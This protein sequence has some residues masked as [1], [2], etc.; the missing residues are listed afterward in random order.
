MDQ[1]VYTNAY[2]LRLVSQNIDDSQQQQQQQNFLM[3][4]ES[5]HIVYSPLKANELT[6]TQVPHQTQ[7]ITQDESLSNQ[8]QQYLIQQQ[9]QTQQVFYANIA[10]QNQNTNRVVQQTV[11]LNHNFIQQQQNQQKTQLVL[12]PQQKVVVQR[13]NSDPS[14]IAQMVADSQN[15][16]I[17]YNFQQQ[18]QTIDQT[19]QIIIHQ[20][21]QQQV[22]SNQIKQTIYPQQTGQILSP[23]PQ[24]IQLQQIQPQNT[25]VQPGTK[26]IM[27]NSNSPI[28]YSIIQKQQQQQQQSIQG[29]QNHNQIMVQQQQQQSPAQD[30]S[31]AVKFRPRGMAPMKITRMNPPVL[32]VQQQRPRAPRFSQ[33]RPMIQ[34]PM[35]Q[36]QQPRF[37]Q[38]NIANRLSQG[39]QSPQQQQQQTQYIIVQQQD[40]GQRYLQIAQPMVVSQNQSPQQ[41]V[42]TFVQKR[43]EQVQG[44]QMYQIQTEAAQQQQQQQ[45]V[46]QANQVAPTT[47]TLP[48]KDGD[49]D[50]LEDSITATAIAK[51]GSRPDSVGQQQQSNRND[52]FRSKSSETL[53]QTPQRT[54]VMRPMMMSP[55]IRTPMQRSASTSS[56]QIIRQRT[57]RPQF[58]PGLKHELNNVSERESAKMLVIL[59]NGEQRLITFTLPKETCTV[60]ELLDQV[61]IEIGADSNI[62]CIEN[63]S[64]EI[65]YIV[66]VGNFETKDTTAMTKAAEN[67]IR[68]QQQAQ[69]LVQT[70]TQQQ[71]RSSQSNESSQSSEASRL[72]PAKYVEGSLAVCAACGF[73]GADHAKCERCNRVFTDDVKTVKITP[74]PGQMINKQISVGPKLSMTKTATQERKD[75]IEA[76]QKKHQMEIQRKQLSARGGR[77]VAMNM[78]SG[79]GRGGVRTPRK[80]VQTEIVTLSS[81]EESD[82]DGTKSNNSNE[83]KVIIKKPYEPDIVED[84]VPDDFNRVDVINFEEGE[85]KIATTLTCR[86]IRIGSYKFDSK[87]EVHITSKG[88]RIVAPSV[89]N[90]KDIT[91]LNIQ[92]SEIIKF[93]THFSKQ[94]SIVFVYTKPSCGKYIVD[95]LNMSQI[96]D[97]SP[98][99]APLSKIETQRK[100]VFLTDNVSEETKSA[101]RSIYKNH[102][103][104]EI[105]NRDA[106]ELLVR[107]TGIPLTTGSSGSIQSTHSLD[108]ST[109]NK[110]EEGDLRK[111]LTYPKGRG[112]LTITTYDYMCLG[113]D[114]YLNDVIIDFYLKYVHLEVL[115]E[116][117]R[118]KTHIFSQF[119]Y[120]RLTTLVKD[121]KSSLTAA[122]KRH[123]RVQ[124]WTKNVN[125]FEK[126]FII[127]PINEQSHWFLAIICFPNL[128]EPHTMDTN[129]PIKLNIPVKGA[130]GKKAAAAA[131]LQIGNTT[132]T[133]LTKTEGTFEISEDPASERDEAEGDES[134]L[135]NVESDDEEVVDRGQPVKVPCILIFDSLG[136]TSRARVVATLRD[137]LSCEYKAKYPNAPTRQYTKNN[138]FGCLVKV[139]QQQNFTDC[140]LFLLQYVEHFFS[141]PIEDFRIP[142][143][144][145]INWFNQDIVT[146]KREDISNL[147][148]KL[149]KREGF[150]DTDFPEIE[151][152]TKDGKIL[153]VTEQLVNPSTE[154]FEESDFPAGEEIKESLSQSETPTVGKKVYVAKKRPL[155]KID[156]SNGDS[157]NIKSP[158]LSK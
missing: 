117:Q 142:I 134:E 34:S 9:G 43:P 119:F 16:T 113:S 128:T 133:P 20:P 70:P 72:P 120:K 52:D 19:H 44:N 97:K 100:I 57:P 139:P 140:G 108:S 71:Q 47:S 146:R 121:P 23:Q 26:I 143:K 101:L 123:Q 114:N 102:V 104:E 109:N 129:Q 95:Q 6:Q 107:S 74:K 150:D 40:G 99:Y 27:P 56:L 29:I 25:I 66:K 82:S 138:M 61:G 31:N 60:Q 59:D 110:V 105:N 116:K 126:D 78:N 37:V 79:R 7:Y 90:V 50:D 125:L 87:E 63:P 118:E 111:L 157:A 53:Q 81:D 153:E 32:A 5:Q 65:D 41:I 155:D 115:T 149:M 8:Q 1:Q 22:Q 35:Q 39:G 12:Q 89:K 68:Q 38:A 131:A 85:D 141:S 127:V 75:Q 91:V 30:Q 55:Q 48:K 17:Q 98:Y 124:S 58:Q 148:K 94:L 92:H 28:R 46:S 14:N 62:E 112:G 158:R 42:R 67:H 36:Q 15:Q 76:I 2:G 11:A 136:G 69:R 83:K 51:G 144:S 54:G 130:K 137:Y 93:V 49:C 18:Q 135:S 152:P 132:I 151:F 154:P 33:V 106:N 77:V 73:S 84:V 13:M 24:Y 45:N 103:L 4:D 3:A 156:N 96:T 86:T 21:Q 10:P 145:L 147:I 122:Q 64:S 88:I 80:S